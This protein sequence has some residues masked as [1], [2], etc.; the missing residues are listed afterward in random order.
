[1]FLAQEQIL[2]KIK[3]REDEKSLFIC[4]SLMQNPKFYEELIFDE[5]N[6]LTMVLFPSSSALDSAVNCINNFETVKHICVLSG[7]LYPSQA[8]SYVKEISEGFGKMLFLSAETFLYWFSFVLKAKLSE[9][10]D[11][12]LNENLE[13]HLK[14][15]V[16]K[17]INRLNKII[18]FDSELICKEN[19]LYKAKYLEVLNILKSFENISI[20]LMNTR[21]SEKFLEFMTDFLPTLE[22]YSSKLSFPKIKLEVEYCFSRD[23]QKDFLLK[24][25]SDKKST[26]VFIAENKN[27]SDLTTYFHKRNP[28]LSF[29]FYNEKLAPEQRTDAIDY[30]LNSEDPTLFTSQ[31]LNSIK[32]KKDLK[33]LV[34]YSS[35]KSLKEFYEDICFLNFNCALEEISIITCED[36]FQGGTKKLEEEQKQIELFARDGFKLNINKQKYELLKWF[37]EEKTCRWFNLEKLFAGNAVK[38]YNCNNCDLCKNKK[39]SFWAK[40]SLFS[41]KNK[42][43]K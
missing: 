1:M 43:K 38:K 17:I 2:K 29:R 18:V 21:V 42:F 27:L 4:P 7:N 13:L 5:N 40:F 11:K 36:D 19:Y 33:R 31:N 25:L 9:S 23:Q 24:T 3:S 12:D 16:L 20:S 30:F 28:D 8:R 41:L 34:Y 39:L 32:L 15:A 10:F 6:D 22:V 35:P 14:D 37:S 26:L